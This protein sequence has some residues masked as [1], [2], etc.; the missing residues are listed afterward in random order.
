MNKKI[1]LF[2]LSLPILCYSGQKLIMS[3]KNNSKITIDGIS[4]SMKKHIERKNKSDVFAQTIVYRL[5]RKPYKF[6][7]IGTLKNLSRID[8][9]DIK[10]GSW[11]YR[12]KFKYI[13]HEGITGAL[14]VGTNNVSDGIRLYKVH[15][16]RTLQE[17]GE[18]DTAAENLCSLKK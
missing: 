7:Y 4:T 1:F 14:L 9:E 6:W 16:Y 2:F 8:E 15:F 17:E 3:G 13:Q 12:P 18:L 10:S 5:L 11:V